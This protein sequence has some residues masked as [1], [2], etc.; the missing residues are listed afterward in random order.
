MNLLHNYSAI[1]LA[2]TNPGLAVCY[3]KT[4]FASHTMEAILTSDDT[5][6]IKKDNNLYEPDEHEVVEADQLDMVF[7]PLLIVDK[8]GYRAGF[9]KGFYDRYLA[10][11]R[12]DCIK[13]GFSYFEPVEILQDRHE[14]DVPLDICVTPEQVY[15]F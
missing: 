15:V 1:F 10:R 12:P 11:C 8:A 5:H 9:G 6:F 7:V 2:F 13:I 14:F 4:D 3:P